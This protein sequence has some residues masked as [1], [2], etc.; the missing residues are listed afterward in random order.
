M[1]PIT[2][3]NAVSANIWGISLKFVM[4]SAICSEIKE[5]TEDLAEVIFHTHVRL[6]ASP[7]GLAQLIQLLILKEFWC[8]R[9]DSNFHGSYPTATSTLRVYQFRHDRTRLGERLI[10][11]HPTVVKREKQLMC[12]V[13]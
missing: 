1:Q 10:P 11:P 3:I 9:E 12:Q 13:F 8:G 7:P 6:V 5:I 2:L 4:F